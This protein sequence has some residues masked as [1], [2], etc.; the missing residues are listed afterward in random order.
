ME[1]REFVE[2][3]KDPSGHGVQFRVRVISGAQKL[4]TSTHIKQSIQGTRT[5]SVVYYSLPLGFIKSPWYAVA[6]RM[7][8]CIPNCFK[9]EDNQISAMLHHYTIPHIGFTI[10]PATLCIKH[11]RN[12]KGHNSCKSPDCWE[13]ISCH[14]PHKTTSTASASRCKRNVLLFWCA[15]I[16]VNDKVLHHRPIIAPA[17]KDVFTSLESVQR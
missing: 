2:S 8:S 15:V 13:Q 14:G 9:Q 11:T 16:T 7:I 5:L 4:A 3:I 12:S 17:H 10:G 1:E 6:T